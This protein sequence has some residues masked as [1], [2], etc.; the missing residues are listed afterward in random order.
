LGFLKFG[1]IAVAIYFIFFSRKSPAKAFGKSVGRFIS[2][3][4]EGLSE[5]TET[6]NSE[7]DVRAEILDAKVI[8]KD[9]HQ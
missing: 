5:K 9:T 3:V 4:R 6:N 7:P 1:L 8:R 2:G